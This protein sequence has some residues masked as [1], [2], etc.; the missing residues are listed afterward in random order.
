ML[1]RGHGDSEMNLNLPSNIR[2]VLH[3]LED[4]AYYE[5]DLN[6]DFFTAL[7]KTDIPPNIL[8]I[9]EH[10]SLDMTGEG[11]EEEEW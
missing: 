7:D 1:N 5:D 8:S 11:V 4:E 10:D 6:D 2:E 3:A 9:L